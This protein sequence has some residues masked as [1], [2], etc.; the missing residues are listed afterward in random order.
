MR[1]ERS[2]ISQLTSTILFKSMAVI[3]RIRKRVGLLLIF[4]GGSLVLFVLGDVV[5]STNGLF[6]RT[7]TT[8]GVVGGEKITYPEFQRKVEE[9][10]ENYKSNQ[11]V[12]TVDQNTTEQL[13]EQA[14]SDFV[15][16]NVMVKQYE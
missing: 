8:L 13:C 16:K 12:E 4:I 14:W 5:T 1:H 2:H 6:G 3:G 10:T 9:M 7:S 11:G 15:N